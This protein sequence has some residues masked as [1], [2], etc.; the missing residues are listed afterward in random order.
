MILSFHSIIS[1]YGFW[2]PN[3]PRGSWSDFVYSW[4]L[5]RFGPATKVNTRRSVAARPYDRQL[6]SEMQAALKYPPV[7]FTGEQAV[8]I[9]QGSRTPLTRFTLAPSCRSTCTW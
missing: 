1:A 5:A 2:L 3:E 4:E 9:V 7:H 8:T 6:K